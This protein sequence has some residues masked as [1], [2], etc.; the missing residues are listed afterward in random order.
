MTLDLAPTWWPDL[1]DVD[2][3]TRTRL[4]ALLD[5]P[6]RLRYCPLRPTPRQHAFCAYNGIEA[7]YG[8]AA[9]GGKSVAILMAAL[10]YVDVP[11]YAAL[12]LR[13]TLEE[14]KLPE[15]L[16]D[17]SHQWLGPTDAA[18]N[19]NEHK[20]T[21]PS[22]ATLNFGY[23]KN[24]GS[25]R[26]YQSAAYQFI[27]F[28][29]ATA[30]TEDQYTYLFA[31]CRKPKRSRRGSSP[32]GLG[33]ADVPL[34]VRSASNPGGE[35]HEWCKTRFVSPA[36]RLAPFF[37]S[38]LSDNPH[39][40]EETYVEMMMMMSDPV[41]RERMMAGDWDVLVE[42]TR[43]QRAWFKTWLD[44]A[45]LSPLAVVRHWDLAATEVGPGAS[46]PD[47]TVGTK[48]AAYPDGEYAVLDVARGRWSSA[49]VEALI[50]ATAQRDGRGVRV[51]IEQEPGSAGKKVVEDFQN[52]VLRGYIVEGVRPTGSKFT[53]AG[54]AA[55]IAERGKLAVVRGAWNDP[56]IGELCLF[57]EGT[58]GKPYRGHDDQVDSLSGAY[59]LVHRKP[60]ARGRRAKR[61]IPTTL[62]RDTM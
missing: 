59:E 31:R 18:W 54:G 23:L 12:L 38:K 10:A 42:G 26:R 56:W 57:S 28:D 36:S 21:F 50:K 17:L 15:A 16:I 29:E 51:G 45:P 55:S 39:L 41:T 30:F 61:S 8:G 1:D 44:A 13:R 62:G 22:R 33:L 52:R 5:V 43:F 40:D 58:P 6:L 48:L 47:F 3:E 7:F 46:D 32:D 9:G 24:P 4:L 34:R 35:G 53:R 2:D 11:G 19:G 60:R 20:W 14:L 25:E 27:G 37:P 49:K